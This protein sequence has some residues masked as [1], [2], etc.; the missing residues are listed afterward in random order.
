MTEKKIN[1]ITVIAAILMIIGMVMIYMGVETVIW[2]P[3]IV[4]PMV[5]IRYMLY[6]LKKENEDEK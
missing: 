2:F 1:I 5:L 6:R 3:F 4:A